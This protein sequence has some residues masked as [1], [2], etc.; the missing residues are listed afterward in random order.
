[1]WLRLGD[2]E[3][4]NLEYVASIKKGLE[5]TIEIQFHD[6]NHARVLPFEEKDARNHAFERL[7]EN[8]I[9]LRDAM[10]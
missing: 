7:V 9:K 3:M 4:I 5:N 1:M 10:E 2:N 8:L 6:F